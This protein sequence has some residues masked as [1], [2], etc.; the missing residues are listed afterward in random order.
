ML[1]CQLC[2]IDLST[3]ITL[4]DEKLENIPT[5]VVTPSFDMAEAYANRPDDSQLGVSHKN[6]SSKG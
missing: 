1:L 5:L 6:L 3:P 2:G 4:A